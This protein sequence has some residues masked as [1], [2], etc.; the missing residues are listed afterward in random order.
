MLT[1][2]HSSSRSAE[3]PF[4]QLLFCYGKFLMHH[5]WQEVREKL[6][7]HIA[8]FLYKNGVKNILLCSFTLIHFSEN[9][10][11]KI[12]VFVSS[13]Y[14]ELVKIIV[15]DPL[16]SIAFS[17]TSLFVAFCAVGK[18]SQKRRSLTNRV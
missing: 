15:G 6:P 10:N 11:R 13:H 5:T 1:F 7:V 8:P 9:T 4:T 2:F 3:A 16:S 17:K 14:S 18:L 12:S